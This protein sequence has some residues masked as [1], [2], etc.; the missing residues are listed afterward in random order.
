LS[1]GSVLSFTVLD[2][3][4]KDQTVELSLRKSRKEGN[5]TDDRVPEVGE[6]TQA[7]VVSTNKKGCFVRCSRSIN[8]RCILKELSDGFLSDPAASFPSGRL[9]VGKV[10]AVHNECGRWSLDLNLRE[11][12][13]TDAKKALELRDIQVGQKFSG[14]VSRIEDYGVFVQLSGS[15]VFGL[16]HKSEC[17]DRFVKDV[18][19]VYSPG[20]LVKVYVLKKD[21]EKK[22]VGLSMKASYFTDEDEVDEKHSVTEAV[23]SD[24]ESMD[25][26]D[27]SADVANMEVDDEDIDDGD[28][29]M[30]NSDEE[31]EDSEGGSDDQS[32]D[33]EESEEASEAAG[34]GHAD[35]A[36]D[37][38]VGFEWNAGAETSRNRDNNETSS[39]DD[40]DSGE[41]DASTE[42]VNHSRKNKSS[43]RRE[44]KHI[45]EREK[46][47][48]DGTADENPETV[49]DYERLVTGNPNSSELWIRYMAFHLSLA[50]LEAARRVAE[51]ALERIEF[52]EEREKLNVW[53]ALLTLEIKYGT[54]DSVKATM[55]RACAQSNPK[56]VHLRACEIMESECH[57]LGGGGGV[58]TVV[59]SR[60]RVEDMYAAACKKFKGKKK[61]W[62]A[63]AAY[64]LR[65]GRYDDALSVSKRSL[66][67]LP[68]YKHTEMM[69]RMA[70]LLFE[71]DRV[72]QARTVFDGLLSKNPK[73][74]DLFSV[75]V[76][77]EV[78]HGDADQARRLFQDVAG[79]RNSSRSMKL[80]EK[81]M[82]KLFKRWY[83]FEEAHGT[84]E[85]REA[86][87]QAAIQ[88]VEGR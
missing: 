65:H 48:A 19:K 2:L 80:S 46:A 27:S 68:P 82:K 3:S 86:V 62:V 23:S 83:T 13:V 5:L 84:E 30:Q 34:P 60:S 8:G 1:H 14:I 88:Y 21:E 36:M 73:R 32:D 39:D 9:V 22:Q 16:V 74:M 53:C 18:S 51:R 28:K 33:S 31:D 79:I 50:D 29:E 44:E 78:K 67:S 45:S 7:Y 12:A 56:H 17:S 63:H 69:S 54:E 57:Q 59:A 43:R 41:E 38:D 10:T 70:Q 26:A 81:Q 6:I 64:L 47:L 61:V 72:D 76:D 49:G 75:Y 4:E 77:K 58:G 37:M 87:K 15:S 52:R 35:I 40:S 42:N 85:T 20:D 11:S 55:K 71:Y 25:E 24:D 66:L